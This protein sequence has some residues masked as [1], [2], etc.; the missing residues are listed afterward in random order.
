MIFWF[1]R[2][3][4]SVV[5]WVLWLTVLP[6][7]ILIE[8]FM[9]APRYVTRDCAMPRVRCPLTPRNKDII[10]SLV[11]VHAAYH[12]TPWA[13][14]GAV[15]TLLAMVRPAARSAPTVREVLEVPTSV[16]DATLDWYAEEVQQYPSDTAT[17]IVIICPGLTGRSDEPAV[18]TIARLFVARGW[19]VAISNRPGS[20]N[21]GGGKEQATPSPTA[22][23]VEADNSGTDVP[24]VHGVY[25]LGD[26]IEHVH[27]QFPSAPLFSIGISIG[28]NVL[29]RYAAA[30]GKHCRL[31]G[32]VLVSPVLDVRA[33]AASLSR[34]TLWDLWTCWYLRGV[35]YESQPHVLRSRQL[36]H[37]TIRRCRSCRGLDDALSRRVIGNLSLDEYYEKLDARAG[38]K[39]VAIPTLVLY[40]LDDPLVDHT[41]VCREMSS[42][43][44][45]ITVAT[46][47]GGH[48]AFYSGLLAG[49]S[50]AAE[51]A[52]Q[53]LDTV[54]RFSALHDFTTATGPQVEGG[55]ACRGFRATPTEPFESW[56]RKQSSENLF[57]K[58][59]VTEIRRRHQSSSPKLM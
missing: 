9:Y 49:H 56:S 15:Q 31:Q 22:A 38:L 57:A 27:D 53:H 37:H 26:V 40:S 1:A 48:A 29:T 30:S 4:Y 55:N 39:L 12:P 43:C 46:R 35:F 42:N 54:C 59:R 6:L 18:R 17:P 25:E 32:A 24:D 10:D 44:N 8:A 13:V 14:Y 5:M 11:C 41:D 3:L 34:R 28:A 23:D 21:S 52:Y 20:V 36:D 45:F 16:G 2:F 47:R 19:R 51:T 7:R 50:F 58:E 33:M